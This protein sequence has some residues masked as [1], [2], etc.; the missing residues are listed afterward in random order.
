MTA[1]PTVA[2]AGATGNLGHH[3]AQAFLSSTFRR[4]FQ[5]IIILTRSES[6]QS[7]DYAS[8][9]AKIRKYSEDDLVPVLEGVD[10]LIS[11]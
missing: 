3:V 1:L 9:G 4:S 2:I 8:A 5:D 6:K 11:A 10:I 7:S